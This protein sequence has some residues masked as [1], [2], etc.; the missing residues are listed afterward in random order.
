[1][2]IKSN[3]QLNLSVPQHYRDL[4]RKMAAERNLKNPDQVISGASIATELLIKRLNE[5]TE[6]KD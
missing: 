3:V 5:I 1:M 4:L 2:C 6:A